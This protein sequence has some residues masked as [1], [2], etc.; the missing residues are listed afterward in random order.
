MAVLH[1]IPSSGQLTGLHHRKRKAKTALRRAG[2]A[3]G[4]HHERI[5]NIGL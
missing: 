5:E 4:I 2:A 1:V 3:D